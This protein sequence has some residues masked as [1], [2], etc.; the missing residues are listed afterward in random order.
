MIQNPLMIDSGEL[1]NDFKHL[2]TVFH[3]Q[4]LVDENGNTNH[5][6]YSIEAC[7]EDFLVKIRDHLM[8]MEV[9]VLWQ[10]Y[11][12]TMDRHGT[13]KGIRYEAY[14]H[15]KIS[16]DGLSGRAMSLTS[17]ARGQRSKRIE[18]PAGLEVMSLPSNDIQNPLE[19]AIRQARRNNGAYLLP[20]TSNF[21]IA[22][23]IYVSSRVSSSCNLQMK[24]GRS[25]PLAAVAANQIYAATR[26]PLIFVV[27]D[28]SVIR[29]R[30]PFTGAVAGPRNWKQYR[31]ILREG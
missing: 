22:D 8:R 21:P 17:S 19:E 12:C 31:I 3:I 26:A 14:A 15:K 9:N 5:R 18:I 1:A 10:I 13:L 16:V 6:E 23:S 2:W 25:K 4:P 29:A 28:E 30:L 7:H 24:A 20:E 11:A 27:P